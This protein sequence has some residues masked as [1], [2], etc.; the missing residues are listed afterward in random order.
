MIF[1]VVLYFHLPHDDSLTTRISLSSY[2]LL[3][4]TLWLQNNKIHCMNLGTGYH[5]LVHFLFVGLYRLEFLSWYRL[6]ILSVTVTSSTFCIS[7]RMINH[8]PC[9]WGLSYSWHVGI[10]GDAELFVQRLTSSVWT[11]WTI[12]VDILLTSITLL[13]LRQCKKIDSPLTGK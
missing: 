3:F 12:R 6:G 13:T 5:T 9:Y 7:F 10:N 11:W 2:S 1:S 4:P 8:V